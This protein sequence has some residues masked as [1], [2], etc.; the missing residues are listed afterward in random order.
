MEKAVVEDVNVVVADDDD[1]GN[2]D[3]DDDDDDATSREE[4]LNGREDGK[5]DDGACTD[6]EENADENVDETL[7]GKEDCGNEVKE[8]EAILVVDKLMLLA[9]SSVDVDDSNTES[10]VMEGSV[11][12]VVLLAGATSCERT[13]SGSADKIVRRI[14]L[15]INDLQ[16]KLCFSIQ[17]QLAMLIWSLTD[18]FASPIES[19]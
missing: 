15:H 11:L 8:T 1:S 13:L 12:D 17:M 16:P 4:E 7:R 10:E 5:M 14:S 18:A 2:D 6:E 9:V 3:D 19:K